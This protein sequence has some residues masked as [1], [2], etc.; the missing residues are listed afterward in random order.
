MQKTKSTRL[1]IM[2]TVF[3]FRRVLINPAPACPPA[4][5]TA[6]ADSLTRPDHFFKKFYNRKSDAGIWKTIHP[7][8]AGPLSPDL[9]WKTVFE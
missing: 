3:S 9:I 4:N 1:K 2:R 6:P 5:E 7:G 8:S